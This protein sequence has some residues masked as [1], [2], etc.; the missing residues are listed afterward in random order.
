MPFHWRFACKYFGF[1]ATQF[2]LRYILLTY[3]LIGAGVVLSFGRA[4]YN[5]Y[6]GYFT[7]D[8]MQEIYNMCVKPSEVVA[9][10]KAAG[11]A[12]TVASAAAQFGQGAVGPG[13]TELNTV[14]V[15]TTIT[16]QPEKVP[17]TYGSYSRETYSTDI[18]ECSL[19]YTCHYGRSFD[20]VRSI[21]WLIHE[22]FSLAR[23]VLDD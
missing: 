8:A 3:I 2:S 22:L 7:T 21:P 13:I 6:G 5:T 10:E 9:H 14:T 23:D 15:K 12:G 11:D 4:V 18:K 17:T 20:E 19:T 1:V 16:G